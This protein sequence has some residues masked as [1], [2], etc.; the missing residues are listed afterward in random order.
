MTARMSS[1][2]NLVQTVSS[3]FLHRTFVLTSADRSCQRQLELSGS[4][5]FHVNGNAFD[6][7]VQPFDMESQRILGQVAKYYGFRWGGDFK[8]GRFANDY[9][10]FDDG[11]RSRPGR[12]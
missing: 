2:F 4:E 11:L 7:V 10:H 3:R 9:V 5:S 6:A 1:L 8:T 12:C